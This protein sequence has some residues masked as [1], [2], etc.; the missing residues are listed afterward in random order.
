MTISGFLPR[1]WRPEP[2]IAR[3]AEAIAGILHTAPLEALD[4]GPAIVSL[5][6]TANVLP[7][8]V[9][10]K[11]LRHQFGHGAAVLIDDGTLTGGD[12]AILAHHCGDP[13]ILPHQTVRRG[14]FPADRGWA[15]LLTILDRRAGRYWIALEP[16][17]VAL[18][19]LREIGA[20]VASNRSFGAGFAGLAGFAA[21]GAGRT[22]ARSC[23]TQR[24]GQSVDSEK[25]RDLI[26]ADE[27]HSI[28]LPHGRYATWGGRPPPKAAA[29]IHFPP[30]HRFS[31]DGYAVASIAAIARLT[32]EHSLH[33]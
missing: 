31:G 29:L 13:E 9:A 27:P 19:P 17:T 15:L 12:R 16:H 30:V 2:E 11:S 23:L 26:L 24:D 3:H 33:R 21:G 28:E 10:I 8:L 14:P 5:L 20:A 32:A 22:L 18:G 7:Y 4:E 25:V 6:G 1:R